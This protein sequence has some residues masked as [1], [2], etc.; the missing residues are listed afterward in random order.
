M[1]A[2]HK[3]FL[4]KSFLIDSAATGRMPQ[5]SFP[6]P[7]RGPGRSARERRSAAKQEYAARAQRQSC[8]SVARVVGESHLNRVSCGPTNRAR[9]HRA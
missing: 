9:R 7:S 4:H 6:A 5:T 2:L 1:F 3:H 8:W